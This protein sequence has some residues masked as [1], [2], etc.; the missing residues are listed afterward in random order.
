MNIFVSLALMGLIV[1]LPCFGPHTPLILLK[2]IGVVYKKRQYGMQKLFIFYIIGLLE[3]IVYGAS[4]ALFESSLM[5][6]MGITIIIGLRLFFM[7]KYLK[8]VEKF[9][10]FCLLIFFV[11]LAVGTYLPLNLQFK[12]EY[13]TIILMLASSAVELAKIIRTVVITILGMLKQPLSIKGRAIVHKIAEC[14][15]IDINT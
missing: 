6:C 11:T 10:Y 9:K 8:V 4:V 3:L 13:L 5:Q 14:R 7:G 15:N 2:S 1:A 12:A